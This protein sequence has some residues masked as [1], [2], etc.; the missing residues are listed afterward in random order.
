MKSKEALQFLKRLAEGISK[1]FG[2]SCETVIH[3][4]KN[5]EQSIL[6]IYNNEV[7]KRNPGDRLNILGTPQDVNDFYNGVDLINCQGKTN[8]GNLIKSS[9]FHLKG[10]EYH[11]ALGINFDYTHLSL[12]ESAL[13]ELTKVGESLETMMKESGEDKIQT[14]FNDCLQKV[15]KP[16]ALMNK[17]DRLKLI[18]LLQEQSAFSFQKSII[19]ISEKLNVSR[20]TI[21]NYLKEISNQDDVNP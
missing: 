2:S 7:T 1:T 11:Y 8:E 14:I 6:Y 19:F 13:R 4:M 3:D 15:G 17:K 9:T 18:S 12:A 21:Y 20:F 10:K 5:K 16:V